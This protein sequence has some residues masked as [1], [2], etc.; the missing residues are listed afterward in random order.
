MI[1]SCVVIAVTVLTAGSV[2]AACPAGMVEYLG[3]CADSAADG[4]P[5]GMS[6][7]G[8]ICGIKQG[9]SVGTWQITAVSDSVVF[10]INTVTGAVERCEPGGDVQSWACRQM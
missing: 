7:V 5:P 2:K 3:G 9:Y 8:G 6:D 10:R 1:R 4:C